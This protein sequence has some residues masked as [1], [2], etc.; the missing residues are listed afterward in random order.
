VKLLSEKYTLEALLGPEAKRIMSVISSFK[1]ITEIISQMT[2]ATLAILEFTAIIKELLLVIKTTIPK[3]GD[4]P[5]HGFY[6]PDIIVGETDVSGDRRVQG[7][8]NSTKKHF[9]S[10]RVS[11][12][13]TRD[14]IDS[15]LESVIRSERHLIAEKAF[16]KVERPSEGPESHSNSGR[17]KEQFFYLT[18]KK[19]MKRKGFSVK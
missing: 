4:I 16:K 9:K 18:R 7:T 12:K 17:S 1:E 3:T 5:I 15:L 8:V 11:S 13:E 6:N 19:G 2:P 10:P 14:F